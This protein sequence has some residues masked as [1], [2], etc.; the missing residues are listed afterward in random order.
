[1]PAHATK[2]DIPAKNRDKIV[3]LLN[4]QLADAID[5]LSQVKQAHW[6]VKGMHFISL[7]QLFDTLAGELGPIIDDL[8]E[9]A[10]ALGGTAHGTARAVAKNSCLPEFPTGGIQGEEAVEALVKRYALVANSTRA[11]VEQADALKDIATADL[12]T[13][14]SRALDKNLWFLEAHLQ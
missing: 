6:N 13:G 5:L 2:I 11:A 7:H 14:A 4:A 8:A 1:M 10:V 12:L 3:S 9:R